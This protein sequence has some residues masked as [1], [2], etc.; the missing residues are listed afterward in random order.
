MKR[1]AILLAAVG[2]GSGCVVETNTCDSRTLSVDWAFVAPDGIFYANCTAAAVDFV[3]VWVDGTL[4]GR[5]YCDD[6]GVVFADPPSGSH[7]VVVEGIYG[8][9]IAPDTGQVIFR[10]WR[11]SLGIA[12]CGDTYFPADP[13]EAFLTVDYLTD[14][15]ACCVNPTYLWYSLTDEITGLSSGIGSTN[16]CSTKTSK[17]CGSSLAFT[18]PYGRYTLDWISEVDVGVGPSCNGQSVADSAGPVTVDVVNPTPTTPVYITP[19][20]GAIG[21]CP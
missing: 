8:G 18:V 20:F 14:L 12:S 17:A 10:D 3:D 15:T 9:S 5:S 1:I 6:G 16:S 19:T 21:T 13:G 2:L 7:E 4:Y 11:S